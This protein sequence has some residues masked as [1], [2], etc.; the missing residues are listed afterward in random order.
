MKKNEKTNREIY[1]R[2]LVLLPSLAVIAVALIYA[3]GYVQTRLIFLHPDVV[4]F[5]AVTAQAGNE[6]DGLLG[7]VVTE[8]KDASGNAVKGQIPVS[9]EALLALANASE[10]FDQLCLFDTFGSLVAGSPL[11]PSSPQFVDLLQQA[12]DGK[13]VVSSPIADPEDEKKDRVYVFVPILEEFNQP[14]YAL[15]GEIPMET[16]WA[17]LGRDVEVEGAVIGL[18]NE[19]GEVLLSPKES[20]SDEIM[21][22]EPGAAE[23]KTGLASSKSSGKYIYLTRGIK[24]PGDAAG[25]TWT[26]LMMKPYDNMVAM[27]RT[28]SFYNALTA[29]VTLGLMSL[30]GI[31]MNRRIYRPLN[32]AVV[33]AGKVA[34]GKLSVKVPEEGPAEVR[35]IAEAINHMVSE[36][37]Y[38]RHTLSSMVKTRTQTL[39]TAWKSLEQNVNNLQATYDSARDAVLVVDV[40]NGKILQTNRRLAELFEFDDA[41]FASMTGSDFCNTLSTRFAKSIDMQ[42]RW[43]YFADNPDAE[44][45]EEWTLLKPTKKLLTV[46][47]APVQSNDESTITGRL[48]T[49]HDVTRQREKEEKLRHTQRMDAMGHLAG[50]LGQDF[51][52]LLTVILGNMSFIRAEIADNDAAQGY[53][54][55]AEDATK[56]ATNLVKQLLGFSDRGPLQLQTVN[57]NEIISQVE[58]VISGTMDS[59]IKLATTLSSSIWDV[60]ADVDQMKQVILNLCMN[61]SDAMPN[62]GTLRLYTENVAV[63]EGEHSLPPS[64]PPG[65]YVRIIVEDEGDGISPHIRDHV[66][67]PFFTTKSEEGSQGLGLAMSYGAVT[68]HGGWITCESA[69]GEGSR[70]CIYLQ[71]AKK[72]NETM[73]VEQKG[74]ASD[75]QHPI[76]LVVDDEAG[77]RRIATS[78]LKRSDFKTLEARDGEEAVRIFQERG[79]DIS[80]VLL[81]LSMPKL[82]GSETFMALKEMDPNIPVLLCSGYPVAMDEFEEETGFRPDGAMQKPFDV[83][84]L[85]DTVNGLMNESAARAVS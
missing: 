8:L 2:F 48:W 32:D 24:Q 80:V 6:L 1:H 75:G 65:D 68:K 74:D 12:L 84:G 13:A 77:V 72:R 25:P 57:L 34:K 26:V 51:N 41:D 42:S 43:A 60:P 37:Q 49:F 16:I 53:L 9:D 55:A 14:Q 52:N 23:V 11:L 38:H 50:S 10:Y 19:H 22:V 28:N 69:Q 4:Q 40:L 63:K 66:F 71:R 20:L 17:K 56:K 81:D 5:E 7:S 70:F 78:V 29:F 27:V 79:G 33:A 30:V 35:K 64:S 58:N 31:S 45:T 76:V 62:G 54:E 59:R 21:G 3:F 47:T 73:K 36:V 15:C 18:L 61:A 44:G 82:S 46:Y 67:E 83:M 39:E 85:C